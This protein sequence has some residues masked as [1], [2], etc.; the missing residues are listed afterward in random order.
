M[1]HD[2]KVGDT[3]KLKSGGPVMTI[4]SIEKYGGVDKAKCVWFDR[5]IKKD[6]VFEFSTLKHWN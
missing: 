3:V 4:E 6:D 1:D 2:F 5:K